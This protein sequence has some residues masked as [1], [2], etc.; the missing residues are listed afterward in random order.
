VENRSNSLEIDVLYSLEFIVFFGATT[1]STLA[2][3]KNASVKQFAT[4]T[5]INCGVFGAT[6]F[7]KLYY[8]LDDIH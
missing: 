5:A 7:S 6:F 3:L 8:G 2:V 4:S 1:G